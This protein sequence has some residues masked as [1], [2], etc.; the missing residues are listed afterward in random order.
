MSLEGI[1]QTARTLMYFQRR[2]EVATHNLANARSDA[3]KADRLTARHLPGEAFPVPVQT[4][5]LGQGTFRE[6]A[7]PLDLAL[8]GPGFLVVRDDQGETLTRGGSFSLDAEGRI[9]DGRG[10]VL[11][12]EGGPVRVHGR[13][14]EVRGDGSVF[15]D[16]ALVGALR[17]VDAPAATALRKL[18]HGRYQSTA[19]LVPHD[20]GKVQIRQGAV[21]ESNLDPLLAMVDLITIQR[22]YGANADALK[23]LDS[24]LGAI[25]NDV[26]R[27][28]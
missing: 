1:T 7:R 23:A 27:V 19:P 21:E 16:G 10:G 14:L 5:D 26:G 4:V 25:T 24:V 28:G 15:V 6:T 18:G 17:I 3:Y 11:V 2:Q 12:G 20:P 8:T 13:A 22:A 9:T